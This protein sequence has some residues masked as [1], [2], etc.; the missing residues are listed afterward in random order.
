MKHVKLYE[1]FLGE[2]SIGSMKELKSRHKEAHSK[3]IELWAELSRTSDASAQRDLS[4]N[5]GGRYQISVEGGGLKFYDG[6]SGDSFQWDGTDW[7]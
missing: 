2:S 4:K 3:L 6:H 5:I 1:E 7:K